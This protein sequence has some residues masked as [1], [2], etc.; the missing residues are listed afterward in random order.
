MSSDPAARHVPFLSR[1]VDIDSRVENLITGLVFG[2]NPRGPGL[3]TIPAHD[4][5]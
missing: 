1:Q 5:R 2:L 4:T 3:Q